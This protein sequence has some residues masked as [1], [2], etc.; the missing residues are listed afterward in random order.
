MVVFVFFKFLVLARGGYL[1]VAALPPY[2]V[3]AAVSLLCII[4]LASYLC[5]FRELASGRILRMEIFMAI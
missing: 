2:I 1:C 3:Y 5:G 4:S